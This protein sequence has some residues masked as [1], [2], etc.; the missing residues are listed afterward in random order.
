LGWLGVALVL[1]NHGASI[2]TSVKLADAV[3]I[4]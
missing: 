3:M 2:E 1:Y 4:A